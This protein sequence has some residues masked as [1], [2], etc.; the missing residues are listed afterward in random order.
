LISSLILDKKSIRLSSK[1]YE[2]LFKGQ[3]SKVVYRSCSLSEK[4]SLIAKNNKFREFIIRSKSSENL[5]NIAFSSIENVLYILSGKDYIYI[6]SDNEIFKLQNEKVIERVNYKGDLIGEPEI[7]SL[8][9]EERLFFTTT[10]KLYYIDQNFISLDDFPITL[11][12]KPLIPFQFCDNNLDKI[13]GYSSKK[14]FSICDAKGNVKSKI[15]LKL[16][17]DINPIS[18]FILDNLTGV[19]HDKNRAYFI[20]LDKNELINSVDLVKDGIVFLTDNENQ[21]FFYLEDNKLVR[22]DFNGK[23]KSCA[24]GS[25]LFKLKSFAK[26]KVIGVL[27]SKNLALFNSKGECVNKIK[28]PSS[29]IN[30]YTISRSSKGESFIILM[31]NLSNDFYIYTFDG[32]NLLKAPIKGTKSFYINRISRNLEIYTIFKNKLMKYIK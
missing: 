5:K 26:N 1:D 3:P 16:D 27:T 21:A 9:S 29:N 14:I 25:E 17:N 30:D 28:L 20:N 13:V 11:K 4:R 24:T 32:E 10:E 15:D 31:D 23:L 2:F 7:I 19:V 22:N 6:F 18:Y 8:E 12:N